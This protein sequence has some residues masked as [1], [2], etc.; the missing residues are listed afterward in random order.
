MLPAV[1]WA[2]ASLTLGLLSSAVFAERDQQLAGV[3]G[4]GSTGDG[5]SRHFAL[6]V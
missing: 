6:G 3:D 4:H 5:I 2:V 1:A